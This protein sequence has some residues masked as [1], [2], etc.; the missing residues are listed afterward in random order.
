MAILAYPISDCCGSS[1]RVKDQHLNGVNLST[2]IT[3]ERFM[4]LQI[5]RLPI[6]HDNYKYRG[7]AII[8]TALIY[9]FKLEQ[10]RCRNTPDLPKQHWEI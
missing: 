8:P 10:R 2:Y 4:S 1:K 6:N 5:K 3:D 9:I 7:L